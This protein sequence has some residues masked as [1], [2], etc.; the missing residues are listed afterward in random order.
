MSQQLP[1]PADAKVAF[2]PIYAEDSFTLA[3]QGGAAAALARPPVDHRLEPDW[4]VRAYL[5]A[6]DAVFEKDCPIT[7]GTSCA[8]FGWALEAAEDP[9]R[10][11]I[12]IRGT[13]GLA[14][15]LK[16]GMYAPR[17]HPVAGKVEDGFYSIL[18]TMGLDGV[19]GGAAADLG[20][21]LKGAKSVTITG[22]SLGAALGHLLSF[23]LAAPGLLDVP[24]ESIQFAS[25]RPGDAA[26]GAALLARVPAHR[27][28][29]YE[30]DEV[31][32][33]PFGFGFSP[34]PGTITLPAIHPAIRVKFDLRCFHHALTYAT[35][36][37]PT[38][39][40]SFAALAIDLPFLSC[41][42]PIS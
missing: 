35:L 14:E 2:F 41:L 28:Y 34:V 17:P 16:D 19:N 24:V 12:D 9:G 33:V 32:R 38:S 5:T 1:R 36:L 25:P 27:S 20:R 15:W 13:I 7:L 21:L 40:A 8:F 31:P 11:L 3:C 22:H 10:F 42:T 6:S 4:K 26:F 37:D 30:R 39:L 18:K 29:A 23:D